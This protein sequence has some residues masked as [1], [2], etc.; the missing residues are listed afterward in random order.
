MKSLQ[1]LSMKK[2]AIVNLKKALE[3]WSDAVRNNLIEE[4]KRKAIDKI[5]R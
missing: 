5:I 4:R 1:Q 2:K 3:W